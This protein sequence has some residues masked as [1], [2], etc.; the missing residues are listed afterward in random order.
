MPL[1]HR[2]VL[3]VK[4]RVGVENTVGAT[5]VTWSV[6]RLSSPEMRRPPEKEAQV[7]FECPRC[8]KSFVATVE[9]VARARRK[10]RV[11]LAI[12][13]LLLLSLLVTLPMAFFLGGQVREEDDPSM[14]P[15]AVLVPLVALGLVTGLPFFMAGRHYEGVKKHRLVLPNGKRTML[16]QGHRFD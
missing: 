6:A 14:N 3:T 7:A 10:Q 15:L 4:C 1:D 12:G 9:S 11:Y 2:Y 5:T 8:G 13:L 16:V